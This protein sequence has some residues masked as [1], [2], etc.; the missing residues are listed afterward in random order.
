MPPLTDLNGLAGAVVVIVALAVALGRI[1]GL[2][3]ARL[4]LVA[5]V[6]VFVALV[7]IGALP[8]AGGLRGVV[9]DLSLTTLV[10]LLSGLHRH[11][12]GE[13]P[14]DARS[15][16]AVQCLAAAGGL[17]LY[18]LTLG[19]AAWDPYRLGYGDPWFL[20]VLLAAALAALLL[21]LPLVTFTVALAV[22]AW[23][24][25]AYESR[26]LWD[27]LLDPLVFA[28][29]LGGVFLRGAGALVR[30]HG[31]ATDELLRMRAGSPS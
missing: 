13:E 27:Y 28:W 7:P 8:V 20:V 22:M 5:G 29:G 1:V 18:P 24:L 10:L 15:T 21:D 3:R 12:R 23:G 26:N 25:G 16:F 4:A 2:R 14:V 31:R 9:G 11:L 6:G 30:G 19:L 17:V